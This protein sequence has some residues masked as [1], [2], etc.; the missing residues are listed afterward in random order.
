[1]SLY[2]VIAQARVVCDDYYSAPL[3]KRTCIDDLLR[4]KLAEL[5]TGNMP[6]ACLQEPSIKDAPSCHAACDSVLST[7]EQDIGSTLEPVSITP[8]TSGWYNTQNG[9]HFGEARVV[10]GG[11][12]SSW[13]AN[14]PKVTLNDVTYK[15]TII[16]EFSGSGT[17]K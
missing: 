7:I 8:G 9:E 6:S 3:W 15:G 17:G 10:P 11:T 2:V 1:M 13:G 16:I 5:M 14:L 4:A 12:G